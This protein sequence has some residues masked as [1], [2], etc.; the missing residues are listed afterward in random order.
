MRLETLGRVHVSYDRYRPLIGA[1]RCWPFPLFDL[2]L[3]LVALTT[4]PADIVDAF[5]PYRPDGYT[6]AL[7]EQNLRRKLDSETFRAKLD[8]LVTAWPAGYET[9][10]AG[11]LVIDRILALID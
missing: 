2:W 1:R 9:S 5:A 4:P 10:A 3:A 7:G 8:H 11:D 6:R